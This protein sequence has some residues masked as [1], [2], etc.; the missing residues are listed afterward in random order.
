MDVM[1][2]FRHAAQGFDLHMHPPESTH[3]AEEAPEQGGVA[4]GR[5]LGCFAAVARQEKGNLCRIAVGTV[6]VSVWVHKW[7]T[8]RVGSRYEAA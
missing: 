2:M 3:Q 5:H 8:W 7:C 1:Q 6:C 4:D